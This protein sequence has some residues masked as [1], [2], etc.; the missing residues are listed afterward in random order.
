MASK[1]TQELIIEAIEFYISNL[2]SNF[3]FNEQEQLDIDL[4]RKIVN[5]DDIKKGLEAKG[6]E[7]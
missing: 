6:D 5:L 4:M 1:E 7:D 3:E 2:M